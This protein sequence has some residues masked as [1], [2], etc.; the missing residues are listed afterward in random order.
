MKSIVQSAV[1]G[2]S[3]LLGWLDL[4]LGIICGLALLASALVLCDSVFVRYILHRSTDWQDETAVF[5]LVGAVFL[6]AAKVQSER[7]HIGIDAVASLLGP[8]VNRF[9]QFLTDFASM[10]FVAF[11]SLKSWSLAREAWVDGIVTSSTFGPPL[12]IPY[13]L[14]SAGMTLLALRLLAQV[15]GA[16]VLDDAQAFRREAHH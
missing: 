1:R 4:G 8:K 11:F 5:L 6:S 15:C 16:L 9:R 3:Q 12:W 2:F 14:M 10:F 13:G 7:G